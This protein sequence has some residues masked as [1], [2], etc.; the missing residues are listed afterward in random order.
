MKR[1]E[2]KEFLDRCVETYNR[3]DFIELD[4]VSVPHRF[5]KLQDREI[6]GFLAATLAWG[7]RKTILTKSFELMRLMD[8]APHDF[9]LNS[10]P[11]D[12]RL[13]AKFSHRTF[14]GT[15]AVAF[16]D[17]LSWFYRDHISLEEAFLPG[18]TSGSAKTALTQFHHM[19]FHLPE[20]PART[21]K[22][23]ATPERGSACKRLNMFLR[24]MVRKDQCGVDFGCW[25]RISP[26]LLICPVDLHVERVARKLGLMRGRM[27]GWE[28]A[29]QL[30]RKLRTFDPHDP[31]RYDFAL[32]G[33]GVTEKW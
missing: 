20:I 7:Q 8:D 1:E 25:K 6:A 5:S 33:L 11:S 27:R 15:D 17:F 14:N 3:P 12:K 29:E 31:V 2:L 24:W 28:S 4:P 22:H 10:G 23:V 32:F 26:A 19:F 18:F 13:L 21:R 16:V 30:T 9:V